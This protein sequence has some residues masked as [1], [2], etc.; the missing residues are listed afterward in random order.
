[1]KTKSA[2]ELGHS[3]NEMSVGT[4]ESLKGSTK[5]NE[6]ALRIEKLEN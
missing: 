6:Q 4:N 1:M 5:I 2:E 3:Q